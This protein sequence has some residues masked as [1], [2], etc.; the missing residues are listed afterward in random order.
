MAVFLI[1][2][3]K[4]MLAGGAKILSSECQGNVEMGSRDAQAVNGAVFLALF[5]RP[6]E[7]AVLVF[8]LPAEEVIGLSEGGSHGVLCVCVW[9]G[10]VPSGWDGTALK[11]RGDHQGPAWMSPV[12]C[13]SA[14][15][16]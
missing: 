6:I 1:H 5:C 14:W 8:L 16:E 7:R 15:K 10:V 3:A 13:R 11:V 9:G 4:A 12:S 2:L